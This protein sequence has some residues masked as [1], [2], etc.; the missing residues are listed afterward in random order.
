MDIETIMGRALVTATVHGF[1]KKEPR[2][3]PEHT[4]L[5]HEEVSELFGYWRDGMEPTAHL[6]EHPEKA[7]A[8]DR[9]NDNPY[10]DMGEGLGK[11][12][13]IPSELADVVIRACQFAAEYR[14]DLVRAI[15]E[16]MAYNETRP[17]M[18]GRVH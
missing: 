8:A 1:V 5:L 11:P 3:I 4:S 9:I 17:Y 7:L 15:E 18:H 10:G 16:K 14:I 13:G 6:Y 2:P 12:V